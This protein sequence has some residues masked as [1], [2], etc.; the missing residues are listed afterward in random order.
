MPRLSLLA[1]LNVLFLLVCGSLWGSEDVSQI[2]FR[3]DI[4][5]IL[6]ENCFAC[7]GFDEEARQAGLRLDNVT[8]AT[9]EADSG[10]TAVVPGKADDSELLVRVMSEGDDLRMPPPETEK[11]LTDSQRTLLKQWIEQGAE[12]QQHWAF[13]KPQAVELA[14]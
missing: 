6:S 1:L 10:A 7:H 14:S 12:Y 8:G 9:S 3:R 4:L 11:V 5:P 2:Q 13:E